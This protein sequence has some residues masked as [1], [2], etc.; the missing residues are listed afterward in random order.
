M[1]KQWQIAL[2][3]RAHYAPVGLQKPAAP[4]GFVGCTYTA[5]FTIGTTNKPFEFAIVGPAQRSALSRIPR[6]GRRPSVPLMKPS[7]WGLVPPPSFIR[8]DLSFFT[9]PNSFDSIL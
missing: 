3:P 4:E 8:C 1:R 7:D 9:F 2:P 5:K 6:R